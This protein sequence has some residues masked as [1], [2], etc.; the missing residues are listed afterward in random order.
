[1]KSLILNTSDII[2]GAARA[3]FRLHK[4]LC[5]IGVD[6]KMFVQA[7]DS[8]DNMFQPLLEVFLMM[9]ARIEDIEIEE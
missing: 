8:D 1:M 7:K 5:G 6:S 4:G 9:D 3:A 2:G